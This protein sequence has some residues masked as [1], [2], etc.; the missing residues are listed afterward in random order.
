MSGTRA[1]EHSGNTATGGCLDDSFAY[2]FR[3]LGCS[4]LDTSPGTDAAPMVP[5]PAR[6]GRH[7]P[8]PSGSFRAGAAACG[9]SR[10]IIRA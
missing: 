6:S 1:V 2:G 10:E 8:M 9:D 4:G 3:G 7:G 5:H